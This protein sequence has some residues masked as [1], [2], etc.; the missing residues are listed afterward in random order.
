[1]PVEITYADYKDFGGVKFPTRIRQAAGGFPT[2]DLT[3]TDVK[4]NVAVDI[5][6]PDSVRQAA[7]ALRAGGDPDGGRR[8][9]VP[10]RRH[11]TTASSSR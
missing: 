5:A 4:P 2:L 9:L 10:D 3:V 8:R 11:A 1:M 7:G 6:A